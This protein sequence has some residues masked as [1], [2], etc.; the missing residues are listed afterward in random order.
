MDH[1]QFSGATKIEIVLSGIAIFL[2][3]AEDNTYS[4]VQ[5]SLE[6]KTDAFT[7]RNEEVY[8]KHKELQ[9]QH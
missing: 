3:K 5:E 8:K 1:S 9:R 2:H 4:K 7:C 6:L